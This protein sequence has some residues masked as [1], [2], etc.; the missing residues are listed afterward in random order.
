MLL[1]KGGALEKE[2]SKSINIFQEMNNKQI[3]SH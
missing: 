2:K 1:T 3:I